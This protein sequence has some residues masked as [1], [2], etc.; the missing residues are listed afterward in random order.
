MPVGCVTVAV[1]A[2]VLGK[3]TVGTYAA[4]AVATGRV[5]TVPSPMM[6][7]GILMRIVMPAVPGKVAIVLR[8]TAAM[9]T[10]GVLAMPT[11]SVRGVM[12]TAITVMSAVVRHGV[13]RTGTTVM[14]AMQ[15]SI[16]RPA[17]VL[18]VRMIAVPRVGPM[19]VPPIAGVLLAGVLLAP[20]LLAGVLFGSS[21]LSNCLFFIAEFAV[22][23]LVEFF[24]QHGV[25]L[26]GGHFL[27]ALLFLVSLLLVGLLGVRFLV[28]AIGRGV[29][30]RGSRL[31]RQQRRRVDP[32]QRPT[33][34]N[35]HQPAGSRPN[36]CCISLCS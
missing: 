1:T 18:A 35:D 31:I 10:G 25:P 20:A 33:H 7:M 26:F 9:V 28:V 16:A 24:E 29:R 14:A 12:W 8:S 30:L 22:A 34:R 15:M 11:M 13:A 19:A 32:T 6:S 36:H 3:A 21:L 27:F 23:V 5:V 4:S 2:V 17:G